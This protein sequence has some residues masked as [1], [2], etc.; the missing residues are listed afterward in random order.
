MNIAYGSV[1]LLLLC[2]AVWGLERRRRSFHPVPP[3]LQADRTLPHEQEFELH[4][5]R[6]RCA[7]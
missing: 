7:R 5:T 4:T 3:G 2:A 1:V 6:C